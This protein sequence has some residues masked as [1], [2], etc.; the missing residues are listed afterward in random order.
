MGG[1]EAWLHSTKGLVASVSG[2]LVVLSSVVNTGHDLYI[3]LSG[4]PRTVEEA[5]QAALYKKHFQESPTLT[6]PLKVELEKWTVAVTVDV[7]KNGDIHLSVGDNTSWFPFNRVQRPS[8]VRAAYAE[9]ADTPSGRYIQN[10]REEGGSIVRERSYENGFRETI[11]INRNT[12]RIIRRSTESRALSPEEKASIERG[13]ALRA[14]IDL[15][16][17]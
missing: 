12:G 2:V 1:V 7:Y 9:P 10:Q 15:K 6:Q 14:P 11:V 17:K 13:P 5:S 4:A 3:S 16:I 8:L